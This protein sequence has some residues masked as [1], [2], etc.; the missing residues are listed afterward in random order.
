M[1][2]IDDLIKLANHDSKL[3]GAIQELD[4]LRKSQIKPA[5]KYLGNSKLKQI[6]H[7]ASELWEVFKAWVALQIY[8]VRHA[9]S[10]LT[11]EIADGYRVKMNEL[12]DETIDLQKSCQTFIK[13][14]LYRTMQ[15]NIDAIQRVDEKNAVRGYDKAQ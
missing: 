2:K 14:P 5:V 15:E 8:L 6:C 10:E 12:L 11:P 13:G 7:M 1:T 3:L 9:N 4:Q